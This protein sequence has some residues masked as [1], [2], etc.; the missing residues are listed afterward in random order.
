MSSRK[1]PLLPMLASP[2]AAPFHRPGWVYEQK[3]D[4]YR[5][6]AERR[7]GKA[8]LFTRNRIEWTAQARG[9][10]EA[11]EA[12]RGGDFVLDGEL[13]ALDAAGAPRFQLLRGARE[14]ASATRLVL[15]DCL[16]RDG[17]DLTARPLSERRRALEELLSGGPPELPLAERL[18]TDGL[19]AFRLAA[20][21]GWEGIVAK[22]EASRYEPGRRSPR[23]L[24]VKCRR[25][26][27]F[28]IGGFLLPETPRLHF[29]AL[30]VGLTEGAAVRYCGRVG[31]GFSEETVVDLL[32]RM[33][34]LQTDRCPFEPDP[35]EKGALWVEPRLVAQV[36]Y[37]EWT[38]EGRLRQ[39]SFLG[40]RADRDPS[41]CL[42][43]GRE[44]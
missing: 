35:K 29:G 25:D 26:A 27:E 14:R 20:E 11:L 19:A 42:W 15:F 22:D 5:I 4:G 31:S 18:E 34:P 9:I 10:A 17:A 37:A 38:E 36:A 40:L 33:R 3:V 23:W 13:V 16:E 6:L 12:L 8:R 39:P 30:L 32:G 28:V 44:R 21:K 24:K 2:S 43:S 41:E 7:R 1:G